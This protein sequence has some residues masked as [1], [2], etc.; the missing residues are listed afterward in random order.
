MHSFQWS[1]FCIK[2]T[3]II[4]WTHTEQRFATDGCHQLCHTVLYSTFTVVICIWRACKTIRIQL[5]CIS[6]EGLIYDDFTWTLIWANELIF[7]FNASFRRANGTGLNG[8][9]RYGFVYVNKNIHGI[10]LWHLFAFL[11][12][13]GSAQFA[14]KRYLARNNQTIY[15][16]KYY[17]HYQMHNA[18]ID[19]LINLLT[20]IVNK[21][22]SMSAGHMQCQRYHEAKKFGSRC[23]LF[24]RSPVWVVYNAE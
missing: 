22:N 23:F 21:D 16:L 17:M 24:I 4:K 14:F 15:F 19:S 7:F 20:K 10:D 1:S 11:T 9:N 8:I 12:L 18:K 3:G 2:K 6:T 13:H 5:F